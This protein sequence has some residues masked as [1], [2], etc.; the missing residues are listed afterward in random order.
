M[1]NFYFKILTTII[2]G[3]VI[4]GCQKSTSPNEQTASVYD[5]LTT[6]AWQISP[7]TDQGLVGSLYRF[8]PDGNGTVNFEGNSL[9]SFQ[10]LLESQDKILSLTVSSNGQLVTDRFDILEINNSNLTLLNP[11]SYRRI[12]FLHIENE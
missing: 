9:F 3:L 7:E 11:I 4:I 2:L 5:I 8:L 12:V 6:G 1:K 10:W